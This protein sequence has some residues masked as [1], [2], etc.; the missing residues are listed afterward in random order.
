MSQDNPRVLI[1]VLVYN[2]A[3]FLGD[4]FS[5]LNN[6]N[7]PKEN[8]D[9]LAVDNLSTDNSVEYLKNNWATV[10]LIVNKINLGFAG[11][12]N[13]G[14]RYGIENNYDYVYLLNQDT[15]VDPDF[16]KE[17]VLTATADEKI[18]AVQSKLLLHD[19]PELLNSSGNEINYLGFAFAGGYKLPDTIT[20]DQEIT[21]PSGAC[22]LFKVKALSDVGLF[23]P[24]FFMYHEDTDLGWR[25]W[26]SGYRIILAAKSK[27]F[28]KYEFSRSI[29]KYYFMERNRYLVFF[30]NYRPLTML[31]ILPAFAAMNLAMF[32]Y[33]FWAGWWREE[34]K[35]VAYLCRPSS[36]QKI[37]Q[38][39]N[40]VQAKRRLGDQ[41]VTQKFIGKIE[42][43]DLSNP[44]LKYLVNPVMDYYWTLIKPIIK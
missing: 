40:L 8:Y 38:T 31:L 15:T 42:F 27:V 3:D 4:C 25:F 1:V 11:G 33:S 12:N 6:I 43:Q 21:Y 23:N 22:T 20:L 14:F 44:L 36:W 37:I 34:L 19:H 35:V 16:I 41:I 39:R 32:F 17:A 18:A 10:K 26:I 9:I 13:V 2:G 5:S 28:H 30:Q 7:Y 24:D 29:R